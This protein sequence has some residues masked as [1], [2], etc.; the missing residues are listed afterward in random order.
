MMFL[1]WPSDCLVI[2]S[3]LEAI[4]SHLVKMLRFKMLARDVDSIPTQYRTWIVPNTPDFTG[5]FYT[6]LKSGPNS[7][8]DVSAYE[9]TDGYVVADFDLPLGADWAPVPAAQYSAF[10]VRKILPAP[11]EDS[12]LAIIDGYAYM[13]GGKIT[14][15]I[16]RANLNNPADWSDTGARL[17]SPLY[18][19]SLAIIDG[20]IYLFGGND[21][22]SSTNAIYSASVN[23]PLTWVDDGYLLPNKLQYSSLGM[24]D[25]YL[26]L[27]GG[28]EDDIPTAKI[29]TAIT[30]AP[31]AWTDTGFTLPIAVYGSSLAQ[32]NDSWY[33]FGG[34][35]VSN[36]ATSAILGAPIGM[37]T[38]W[39][40]DGYLPY[41]TSFSQFVTV[42]TDGYLI[43]PMIGSPSHNFTSII[44]C[45]LSAPTIWTDSISLLNTVQIVPGVI[46]HSQLAV[47][48]DR[49]FLF[50]GS[51]LSA[52]FCCNQQ[53]KYGLYDPIVVNYG[54]ITRTIFQS[55]DNTDNPYQ[56]LCY[57]YWISDYQQ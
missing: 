11:I 56:T 52:I 8:V 10:P 45:R 53:F 51:G 4:I 41:Q 46:S 18:G 25:G 40:I 36:N 20:Y 12:C 44:Q 49:I 1:I 15:A 57:P 22:Q 13:F 27:F 5:Q 14:A 50:G 47:I 39:T 31:L 16:Y 29:F 43:G 17:P 32:I 34:H 54:N 19:S 33:M 28:L 55:V 24:A 9:I 30:T 6:G 26:H 2:G 48:Y 38:H 23:D 3:F 7:F 35:L 37:A 42:G 21:G